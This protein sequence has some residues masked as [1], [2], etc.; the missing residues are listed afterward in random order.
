MFLS[1]SA[2]SEFY[3]KLANLEK[4]VP[5]ADLNEY[6]PWDCKL[7]FQQSG[8]GYS[9]PENSNK[10]IEKEK[11]KRLVMGKEKKEEGFKAQQF[12]LSNS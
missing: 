7:N 1:K 10:F 9:W 2:H 11:E 6:I 8:S 12:F 5:Q 4:T 3:V